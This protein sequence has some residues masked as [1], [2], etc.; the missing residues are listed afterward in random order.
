VRLT[1]HRVT[2]H[3]T[4][5]PFRVAVHADVSGVDVHVSADAATFT[6]AADLAQQRLNTR[7][8]RTGRWR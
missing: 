6:E 2:A 5:P 4:R 1:L 7:L 3:G 8:S